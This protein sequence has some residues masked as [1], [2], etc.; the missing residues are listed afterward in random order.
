MKRQLGENQLLQGDNQAALAWFETLPAASPTLLA[1][2]AM[3]LYALKRE[4]EVSEALAMLE[5]QS[6]HTD[7]ALYYANANNAD[8]AIRQL[9]L[10]KGA[11]QEWR[12]FFY[13]EH[14]W[15]ADITLDPKWQ[16]F[17]EDVGLSARQIEELDL[18][19]SVPG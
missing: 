18:N 1:R 13:N 10:G 17:L 12:E 4:K 14:L 7:L 19:V 3:A 9:K 5:E 6:A 2:R 8:N 11:K 16:E 15:A